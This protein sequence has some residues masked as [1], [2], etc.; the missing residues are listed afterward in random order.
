[1]D[2]SLECILLHGWGVSSNVWQDFAGQLKGFNN[3][4]M[5]CLYEIA[6]KTEDN[7]FDTVARTLSNTINSDGIVI[8]WSIGGLIAMHMAS[9][10]N[11][12]K[13]VI[14]IAGTPCF[15]N[16]KGWS[17]AI[18]KKGINDLQSKLSN[19]T[20]STLEYFAGLIAHGDTSKKSTNIKVRNNLADEKYHVI[21]FS[22]LSQMLFTDQRKELSELNIPALFILGEND[23][24]INSKIENQ[25]KRLNSSVQHTVV[26]DC[27]H[28][29]FISK[30]EEMIE[31]IN[32]FIDAKFI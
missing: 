14:F 23:S 15:I 16:K 18:D 19:N 7:K 3:V 9:L 8:A 10:N 22:W 12:I 31:I 17:N 21:L 27:G 11:K 30:P 29:P 13:A 4:S 26:K 2:K 5:P 32:K 28:A 25:I 6:S 20:L 24:L 1:M